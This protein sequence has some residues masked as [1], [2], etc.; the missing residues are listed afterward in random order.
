[1]A[2]KC[3]GQN[4]NSCAS[5]SRCDTDCEWK[6]G[7]CQACP[8]KKGLTFMVYYG[9]G[10]CQA[11]SAIAYLISPTAIDNDYYYSE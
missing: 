3:G 2:V 7:S 10:N 6:E 4:F 8:E 9:D 1:M 11:K 5:C